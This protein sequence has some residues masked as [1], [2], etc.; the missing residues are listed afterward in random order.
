LEAVFVC[1]VNV[2]FVHVYIGLCS[3]ELVQSIKLIVYEYSN[4]KERVH[5]N[6]VTMTTWFKQ[7]VHLVFSFFFFS[8]LLPFFNHRE[9]NT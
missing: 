3:S 4:R 1:I 5:A 8:F 2:N 6:K 9:I 7:L